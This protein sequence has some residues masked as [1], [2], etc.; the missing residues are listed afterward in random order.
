MGAKGHQD[1]ADL[2]VHRSELV[3]NLETR[4]ANVEAADMHAGLEGRA[5]LARQQIAD[6]PARE[7][8]QAQQLQVLSRQLETK[9]ER[10]ERLQFA[11]GEQRQEALSEQR[12]SS[13]RSK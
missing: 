8:L 10:I 2:L 7:R 3:H 12:R 4:L 13:K 9:N 11:L 5:N 6:Q 1:A